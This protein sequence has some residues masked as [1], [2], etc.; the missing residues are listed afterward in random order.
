MRV[1]VWMWRMWRYGIPVTGRGGYIILSRLQYFYNVSDIEPHVSTD[2]WIILAEL[3]GYG[4]Q[5]NLWYRQ[6]RPTCPIVVPKRGP[7]R[8]EITGFT[9][10]HKEVKR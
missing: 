9:Y 4:A 7:M 6:G 10:L 1:K 3:R 8:E 2:H 5:Q